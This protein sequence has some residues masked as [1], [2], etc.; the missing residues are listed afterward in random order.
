MKCPTRKTHHS[1]KVGRRHARP[2]FHPDDN[3]PH[4]E[5]AGE[6]VIEKVLKA[7]EVGEATSTRTKPPSTPSLAL[8]PLEGMV[9][10]LWP[11]FKKTYV[12]I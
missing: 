7:W 2:A 3:G 6:Q 4:K 5:D 11:H 10:K 8:L 12:G 1:N 9:S